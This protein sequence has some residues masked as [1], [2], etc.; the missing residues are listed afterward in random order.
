[1]KFLILLLIVLST[2]AYPKTP[3]GSEKLIQGWIDDLH[4]AIQIKNKTAIGE[5]FH[6]D[7]NF[8]VCEKNQERRWKEKWR[9]GDKLVEYLANNGSEAVFYVNAAERLE[10]G[11]IRALLMVTGLGP[12]F[13]IPG[14][15]FE[16]TD[17]LR[18]K[19]G[20]YGA[21]GWGC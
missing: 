2:S 5:L 20:E 1:M 8:A 9:S 15:R 11:R 12:E 13:V 7:A 16:Q 10:S 4:K 17:K 6:E 3:D 18:Y 19:F 14:M 21:C